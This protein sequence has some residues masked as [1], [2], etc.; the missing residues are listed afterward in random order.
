MPAGQHLSLNEEFMNWLKPLRY[1][2]YTVHRRVH[3][4]VV[5]TW[6]DGDSLASC[7]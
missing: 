3:R 7:R 5:D 2:Y 1:N 4:A 6:T